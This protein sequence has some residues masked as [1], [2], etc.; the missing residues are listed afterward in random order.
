MSA[1]E[2]FAGN[3]AVDPMPWA[4]A[5]STTLLQLG[6]LVSTSRRRSFGHTALLATVGSVAR[7]IVNHSGI[8][9]YDL[10]RKDLPAYGRALALKSFFPSMR[11]VCFSASQA[12]ARALGLSASSSELDFV[13][14]PLTNTICLAYPVLACY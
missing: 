3:V 14:L 9:A 8:T 2:E 7:A 1:F 13:V 5:T 12:I 6:H 4:F 10:S 11:P